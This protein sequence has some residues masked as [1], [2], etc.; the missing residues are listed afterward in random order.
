MCDVTHRTLKMTVLRDVWF[1]PV[2]TAQRYVSVPPLTVASVIASK[3][4]ESDY[5][6]VANNVYQQ[7]AEYNKSLI[8]SVQNNRS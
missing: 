5:D 8:D 7:V 4:Q 6:S 1:V 3:L 2:R